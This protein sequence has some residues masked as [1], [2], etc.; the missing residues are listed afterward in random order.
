MPI[1]LVKDV[2]ETN[3][4]AILRLCRAAVPLMN[5]HKSGN[6][7]NIGSIVGEMYVCLQ[8]VQF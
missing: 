1:E 2:Y 7:I 4:F 6:I 3:V 5:K 8:I